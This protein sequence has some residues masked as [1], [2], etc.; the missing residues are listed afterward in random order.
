MNTIAEH[1]AAAEQAFDR[2]EGGILAEKELDAMTPAEQR[3]F[4]RLIYL[5]GILRGFEEVCRLAALTVT[6]EEAGF[7]HV[8]RKAA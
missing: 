3:E 7:V 4:D 2:F 5:C 1:L 6:I 8:D